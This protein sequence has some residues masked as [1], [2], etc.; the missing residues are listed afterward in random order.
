MGRPS[1]G[2]WSFYILESRFFF[3]TA[4]GL[5]AGARASEALLLQA[6]ARRRAE[7]AIITLY[8]AKLNNDDNRVLIRRRL[9]K[10][11]D[12]SRRRFALVAG[13]AGIAPP[14]IRGAQPLTAET[15]A[16]HI[17]DA[18]GGDWQ[19]NGPDG[20]KAGDPSTIVKGIATTAMATLDVL[21]Q[22][23]QAGTNLVLSYEPTFYGRADGRTPPRPQVDAD[24]R[25]STAD[26]RRCQSQARVHREKPAS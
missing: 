14:G 10:L 21:K 5:A 26:D 1:A 3:G 9:M 11:R 6:S 25:D 16:K 2:V 4:G 7:M 13:A 17:Q 12:I 24:P 8:C 15:A 22:A 20:F 23:A 18:L 19:S